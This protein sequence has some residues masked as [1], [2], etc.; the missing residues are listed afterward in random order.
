MVNGGFI[1]QVAKDRQYRFA[2]DRIQ[3]AAYSLLPDESKPHTHRLIGE[4]LLSTTSKQDKEDRLFEIVDH[5]NKATNS[6]VKEPERIELAR[7][8]FEAGCRA[9]SSIAHQEAI[10]YFD[11]GISLLPDEAWLKNYQLSLALHNAALEASL[12]L[13][14]I[15]NG[16]HYFEQIL[17]NAHNILDTVQRLRVKT[18]ILQSTTRTRYGYLCGSRVSEKVRPW[19][20]ETP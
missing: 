10:T 19:F 20:T 13:A 2:H 14:N 3:Q 18:E 17:Q 6:F 5:F 15:K 1:D 12:L 11:Q 7:L 8:N 16:E 4:S 9:R